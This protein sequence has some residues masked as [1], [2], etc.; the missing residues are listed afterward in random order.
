MLRSIKRSE[1]KKKRTDWKALVQGLVRFLSEGGIQGVHWG[2]AE[3]KGK[4]RNE[5]V[6]VLGKYEKNF[7]EIPERTAILR[8]GFT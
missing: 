1:L 2:K 6:E 4:K 3:V 5:V 7:T 8:I